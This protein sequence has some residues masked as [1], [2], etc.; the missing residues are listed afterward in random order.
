MKEVMVN[1]KLLLGV[2]HKCQRRWNLKGK[3]KLFTSKYCVEVA[4]LLND[5]LALPQ[6]GH[7]THPQQHSAIMHL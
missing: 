6:T 1:V 5:Q 4:A 2:I 3:D 7:I